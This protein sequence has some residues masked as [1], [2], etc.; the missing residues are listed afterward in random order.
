MISWERTFE[1]AKQ[2]KKLRLVW[3]STMSGTRKLQIFE[4]TFVPILF[5]G[6]DALIISQKQLHRVD[7]QYM[8]HGH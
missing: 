5:C 4:S 7:S 1:V 3:N 6:L 2:N 8:R